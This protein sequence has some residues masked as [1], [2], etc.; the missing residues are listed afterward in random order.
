[1]HKSTDT[2]GEATVELVETV[3]KQTPNVRTSIMSTSV[4][5]ENM[6][7]LIYKVMKL[8][9]RRDKWKDLGVRKS[10]SPS[11][12]LILGVV[13]ALATIDEGSEINCLDYEFATRNKITFVPTQYV[14]I[15][16]GSSKISLAGETCDSVSAQVKDAKEPTTLIFGKMVVVKN[17]GVNILI[18]EP[19]KKDNRILTHTH[20]RM[21]E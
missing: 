2:Y 13:A 18:G 5:D 3:N 21:I 14:V 4:S 8:G 6:K 12:Q 11:L 7:E 1:M 17:L 10:K 19:G 16:A 20:K 15:A 9:H